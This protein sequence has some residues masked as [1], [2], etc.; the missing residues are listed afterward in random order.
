MKH[1]A[2]AVFSLFVALIV[3]AAAASLSVYG[4]IEGWGRAPLAA[5]GDA[6]AF[7]S[8]ANARLDA[9]KTGNAAFLLFED[10]ARVG[11]RFVSAG[12]P[13]DE[14][15]VFQVASLSKWATAWGVMA[16]AE[17][18]VIDLD[19]PVQKYLKRWTVPPSE[20]DNNEVTVRRLLSHTAGLTDGLGYAGFAP[21][22]PVQTLP[23]SLT[24]ASDASPGA[25]GRVRVGKHPG[26]GFEYSGGGYTL[27]QLMI[28]DVT[29]RSFND[30]MRETIFAPLGMN[31]S[32]FVLDAA[33]E[34]ALAENYDDAGGRSELRTYTSQ[35][36][37]SLYTTAADLGRFIAAHRPGPDGA[38]A[39]RGVLSPATLKAMRAPAA[40]QF[41]A[42]IWGLGVILYAENGRGDFVIGHD[43]SNEP[44][45]NTTARL[46]PD[47]GDGIVILETGDK[48]LATKLAG[49][50]VFW[51]TG[52]VDTLTV[53][54]E[55]RS[56]LKRAAIIGGAAFLV[57]LL[58]GWRLTRP[59][60]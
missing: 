8:A 9:H 56:T 13:V 7:I 6:A 30:F 45:I 47:T 17:R 26:A 23:Q 37:T 57:A 39:G 4:A 41:G 59:R 18:G 24:K 10:G 16:L 58:L 55:F 52:V 12:A 49:E 20:F 50:W 54:A 43:G 42:A 1:L 34:A 25:D 51:K 60:G 28:E 11:G 33:A 35:A 44:A 19:S 3:A 32:T 38:A 36:A 5:R 48:S 53:L 14:N 40:S 27:L 31:A 46:D 29:G 2:R 15:S 21:G 22:A